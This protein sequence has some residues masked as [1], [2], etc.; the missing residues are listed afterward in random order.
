MHDPRIGRFFAIDPLFRKY[1]HN[2][3]YAFSE[4]R[5][6]DGIELEGAEHLNMH[7][8]RVFK[9][10]GGKYEMFK[11]RE[12]TTRNYPNADWPATKSQSQFNIYGTDGMVR[13]IFTGDLAKL[14]MNKAGYNPKEVGKK[15][16]WS[17]YGK[18]IKTFNP[19]YPVPDKSIEGS[20]KYAT[21]VSNYKTAVIAP[22]ALESVGIQAVTNFQKI[23]KVG[24]IVS[25][26]F[27]VDEIAG[28][29]ENHS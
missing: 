4:N 16:N 6:M 9:G 28:G 22:L 21:T 2:S 8:Y 12:Y 14:N 17:N 13:A 19:I 11:E 3:T 24:T 29:G 15:S 18:A 26:A 10:A 23:E 20:G 25:L 7:V 1:P 27:D 5:V